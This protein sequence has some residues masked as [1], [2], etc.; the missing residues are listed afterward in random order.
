MNIIWYMSDL[1]ACGAIR[2]EIPAREINRSFQ[3]C[4]VICKSDVLVSD[5]FKADIMVFQRQHQTAILE[6]MREAKRHG[7]KC[8][9]E[10]D[11]N[12]FVIPLKFQKPCDFYA[13]PE[14]RDNMLAFMKEADAMIVSTRVLAEQ[15]HAMVP[16]TNKFVVTNSVD[17][18][19]WEVAWTRKQAEQS[20]KLVI[21][22]MASGSHMIDLPLI[23]GALQRI[24][25]EFPHVA[26]HFVGWLGFEQLGNWGNAFKDRIF[27]DPWV[28]ISLLPN[29]MQGFDIGLAPLVD[30]P[31]NLGKSGIK[32]LQYS[33][34][35]IP[36][37]ASPLAP[38]I[39][40]IEDGVNGIFATTEDEWYQ[41]LKKLIEDPAA[42]KTMGAVA[43]LNVLENH[44]IRNNAGHWVDTYMKIWRM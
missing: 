25:T 28:D 20:E 7:I 33:C 32:F 13:K 11:D 21:G 15:L 43:R 22:W 42:R 19:R 12:L 5:I 16:E 18:E 39:E 17:I 3:H 2:G 44:D 38:Y 6:K 10:I 41:A 35:G 4:Q 30:N 40:V 29:V 8:V 26:L 31:F 24:L 37:I 14:V 27:V 23:E 34:L 1:H 9:C 36:T